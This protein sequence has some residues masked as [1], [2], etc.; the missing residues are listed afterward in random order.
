MTDRRTLV[1]VTMCSGYFLVLLDVTIV[2]VA[3][4]RIGSSLHAG[5]PALQWVVD[6]YAIALA[7]LMLAGGTIGD[8]YGH[9]RVVLAGFGLF[10]V[11]S[12]ACGFAPSPAALVGARVV[13]G[14]G[15]A[16][17]LP[18]TL[19]IV[20]RAYPHDAGR[21]RA[22]GLWAAIGS[23]A[24]PAGPLLG[25]VLVDAV[26]WRS[27]FFVNVPVVA[28]GLAATIAVVH[29]SR[30][31]Q[32]R[33]LDSRGIVLGAL[34]LASVTFALI[35]AGRVGLGDRTVVAAAA[36][37][38]VAL[39]A[40]VLAER[41][42]RHPMLPLGLLRRPAFVASNAIAVTMNLATLGM[43]FVVTLYLQRVQQRS[44]LDAG[45]AL[46]PLFAPLSAIAPFAGRITSRS[47]SRAPMAFGLL[48]AAA[49]LALLALA[50]RGSPYGLALV[51]FLL[52]GTGLG[53]LTPAVVAAAMGAVDRARAGLASAM[54][55][56]ARQAGG[57]IGI[58]A[59]GALAGSPA[60][61][62][63][64]LQGMHADALLG[65]VLYVAAAVAA[66]VVIAGGARQAGR[67]PGSRRRASA[68]VS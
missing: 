54:N 19:A 41:S 20:S 30:D 26:G 28:L 61:A 40:F 47:G 6:A 32:G 65:S 48:V 39:A 49:G 36:T 67:C 60:D 21:A 5:V 3:L 50:G 64:F 22:I 45:L 24:L 11:G 27:V 13:Q 29:E 63:R 66:L 8:L 57:A 18:G 62:H 7:S 25:G 55:N 16:L 31:P 33:S 15:A 52:W 37:A 34:L 12:L 53:F 58:A 44:A 51:A 17:L 14:A 42:A 1:L 56:T 4:P 10:A 23:L 59:F 35:E 46:I 9:K 38:A 2:N 43:L 68:R